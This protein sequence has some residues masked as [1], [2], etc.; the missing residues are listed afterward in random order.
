MGTEYYLTLGG[1]HTVKY[2]DYLSQ[3]YALETY[4]I[5]FLV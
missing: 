1:E 4:I 2:T 3:K 5:L